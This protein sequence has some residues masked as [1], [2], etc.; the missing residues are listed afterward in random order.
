M[1]SKLYWWNFKIYNKYEIIFILA[2]DYIL[3]ELNKLNVDY[4]IAIPEEGLKQEYLSRA[5]NRGNEENFIQGFE[6]RYENW[7]NMMISQPVKKI[8]LKKGE[9]I[10]DTLKR[11]K[12]YGG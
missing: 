5:L 9:F 12:L 8:Y 6:T 7:R 2:R 11:M 10:E 3:K 4:V 1:A